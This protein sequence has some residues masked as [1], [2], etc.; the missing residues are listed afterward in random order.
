MSN[1]TKN[2]FSGVYD[3]AVDWFERHPKVTL[4]IGAVTTAACI[5]RFAKLYHKYKQLSQNDE[6]D[7]ANLD[8]PI[9]RRALLATLDVDVPDDIE[10]ISEYIQMPDGNVLYTRCYICKTFGKDMKGMICYNPGYR[11]YIHCLQHEEAITWVRKGF[12]FFIHEHYGHGRSDG[13][14]LHC[15]DFNI[16]TNHSTYIHKYAKKKY[17]KLYNIPNNAYF[18]CGM[19]M[20]GGITIYQ[21]LNESRLKP[22]KDVPQWNGMALVCPVK[23]LYI[24]YSTL[25]SLS[26]HVSLFAV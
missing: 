8:L 17:S 16:Y 1:M 11:Q 23:L 13:L 15:P 25:S 21:I 18:I 26:V 7:K 19:S 10:M 20:G 14:Y 4:G 24:I 3:S 5:L 6:E 22:D 9:A 2:T 12:I